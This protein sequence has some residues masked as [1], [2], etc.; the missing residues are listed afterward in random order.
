MN[1]IQLYSIAKKC[2]EFDEFKIQVA[3]NLGLVVTDQTQVDK[4][5]NY[6][7][8]DTT[9][10]SVI[11]DITATSFDIISH[12]STEINNN[13]VTV[14]DKVRE[15]DKIIQWTNEPNNYTNILNF[16]K[17]AIYSASPLVWKNYNVNMCLQV[18]T[19]N[20]VVLCRLNEYLIRYKDG[21]FNVAHDVNNLKKDGL[22]INLIL[23]KN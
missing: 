1:L 14:H 13:T 6:R 5:D 19:P 12:Y 9:Q 15:I 16:G 3:A 21:T 7:L 4:L 8:Q 17:G 2:S 10:N 22:D 20:G 23:I 18:D 11:S